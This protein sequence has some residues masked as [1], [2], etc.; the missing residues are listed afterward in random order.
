MTE[1][2]S[3]TEAIRGVLIAVLAVLTGFDVVDITPEQNALLLALFVAASVAL[4][5]FARSKVTPTVNVALT[6]DDVTLIEASQK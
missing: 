4:T 5:A 2:L 6:N 1:P 3:R